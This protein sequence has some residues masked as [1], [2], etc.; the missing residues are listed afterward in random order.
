MR[1]HH[2]LLTITMA[3]GLAACQ[4]TPNVP[5][6]VDE[7]PGSSPTSSATLTMLTVQPE[8]PGEP[9]PLIG[10][11]VEWVAFQD[12]NG[13]WKVLEG[14]GGTYPFQVTNKAGKY[15]IVFV[16]PKPT[17]TPPYMPIPETAPTLEIRLFTL[18]DVKAPRFGCNIP[19]QNPNQ[20]SPN[21][22]TV[23]FSGAIKGLEATEYATFQ[24][25]RGS[26]FSNTITINDSFS[27][28][29]PQGIYSVV[30][31]KRNRSASG[32]A[33]FTTPY[34]KVIIERDLNLNADT[35]L[36]FDFA[37][38]GFVPATKSLNFNGLQKD[39]QLYVGG[40]TLYGNATVGL[41]NYS[42]FPSGASSGTM[43]VIPESLLGPD[44]GYVVNSYT[45][46][47]QGQDQIGRSIFKSG[48]IWTSSLTLPAVPVVQ[49]TM[50]S[51]VPY[52][53]PNFKF[54]QTISVG[55]LMQ[56]QLSED[57]YAASGQTIGRHIWN[58]AASGNWFNA[59]QTF[60]APDFSG[61]SGWNA[62]L[63][64]KKIADMGWSVNV[65]NY[66]LPLQPLLI[67][68]DSVALRELKPED[69]QKL[70]KTL[71]FSGSSLRHLTADK[72]RPEIVSA[73]PFYESLTAPVNTNIPLEYTKNFR[74]V[75]GETMDKASVI[76]AYQSDTLPA[77]A[78]T[79]SWP[80]YTGDTVLDITPKASLEVGKTY[81][82]TIG[83]VAKDLSGNPLTTKTLTFTVTN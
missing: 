8:Q 51:E 41:S 43:A 9:L 10:T 69:Q 82:F 63:G 23:R 40:G 28:M 2:A 59:Q 5:I 71:N 21:T 73:S 38:Q 25:Q 47:R 35:K 45:N 58:I 77:N 61:L 57:T 74:I 13:P 7:T 30:V 54:D 79:L 12:G 4:T 3:L 75:F 53:R 80:P 72:L 18:A 46:G 68:N 83:A 50:A 27:Q 22:K 11:N 29:L 16:C 78:V 48:K 60:I 81:S 62:G 20:V 67:L 37:T 1:I 39:E 34:S 64:F 31:G 44:D 55:D 6:A 14:S 70:Y 49:F 66:N 15:G 19:F 26:V 32:A 65:T 52:A 33:D 17:G 76:A 56:L 24:T 42:S 36:D